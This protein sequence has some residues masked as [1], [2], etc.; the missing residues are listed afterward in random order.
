ML[1]SPHFSQ[2]LPFFHLIVQLNPPLPLI[3]SSPIPSDP[4]EDFL[5]DY[6][7]LALSLGFH[8]RVHSLGFM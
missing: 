6:L 2:L 3:L 7:H 5:A 1:L 8:L 4:F